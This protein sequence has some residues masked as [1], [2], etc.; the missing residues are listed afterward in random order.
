MA[1]PAIAA[2]TVAQKATKVLDFPVI[3][4]RR[5]VVKTTKRRITE[6]DYSFQLRGWELAAGGAAAALIYYLYSGGA[7]NGT[8]DIS[9]LNPLDPLGVTGPVGDWAW[10]LSPGGAL[11]ALFAGALTKP[12]PAKRKQSTPVI[13][14]P[15]LLPVPPSAEF[16]GS[17]GAKDFWSGASQAWEDLWG[18]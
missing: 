13:R 15:G 4:V 16:A 6:T 10:R 8:K 5:K 11:Q 14:T 3:G 12:A 7:G 9:K 2:A 1:L 17:S 18:P